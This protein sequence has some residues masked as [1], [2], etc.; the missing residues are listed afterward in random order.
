MAMITEP[1]RTVPVACDVDV[2]IA[3]AGIAGSFAALGAAKEGAKVVL[4]DRMGTVGGNIGSAGYILGATCERGAGPWMVGGRYPGMV[5]Q[6]M[7][8]HEANLN[9]Q[10][11]HYGVMSH[12]ASHVLMEMM[13]ELGVTL[14]LSAYASDPIMDGHRVAGLFVETK[15]G[16]VA[17]KAK[18]VIDDTGDASVAERAGAPVRHFCSAEEIDSPNLQPGFHDKRFKGM[19]DT[20]LYFVMG[21][22]DFDTYNE[23]RNRRAKLTNA[24]KAWARKVL[25]PDDFAWRGAMIPILRSAWLS[26]KFRVKRQIRGTVCVAFTNWFHNL[27]E[28]LTA[29]HTGAYG[30]WDSGDWRDVTAVEAGQRRI[31]YEGIRYFQKH[32]PGFE[33]VHIITSSQ[34]MGARGG[35]FIDAEHVLTPQETWRAAQFPDTMYVATM[36]LHRGAKKPGHDMPYRML[37]PKGVEGLFVTGRGAGFLRRGH[38]PSTRARRSMYGLGYATGLAAAKAVKDGVQPRDIDVKA[39]QRK[40]LKE[41][42]H[43][44][45]PSR[46]KRLGLA[47]G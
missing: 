13:D 25:S 32:V 3:G 45:T 34:F 43:L 46:L 14:M 42:F 47:K 12:S 11:R 37:L 35:P 2:A 4:I 33:R 16:R 23:F 41:G 36:E 44:G 39:F 10:P 38:D 9:G 21:G 20:N 29:V 1:G 5:E 15:S 18:V 22:V 26:G 28:G 19:N 31:G 27:P 30:E 40:L 8:R 7:K 24:E 17:V 6:F